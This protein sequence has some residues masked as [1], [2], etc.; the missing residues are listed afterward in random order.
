M[1]SFSY[2][3]F[4]SG[5]FHYVAYPLLL[6]ICCVNASNWTVLV[7]LANSFLGYLQFDSVSL[8]C[9]NKEI[10]KSNAINSNE[11]KIVT[12]INEMSIC[13]MVGMKIYKA[14]NKGT[15]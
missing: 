15:Q 2:T 3:G 9:N 12:K 6:H 14:Y 7:I 8:K 11:T 5:M 1:F 13:S 10:K 4:V